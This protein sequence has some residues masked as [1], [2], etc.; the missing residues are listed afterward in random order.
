MESWTRDEQ[1]GRLGGRREGAQETGSGNEAAA[2][3]EWEGGAGASSLECLQSAV[4]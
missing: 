1:N 2:Q 3:A 4:C